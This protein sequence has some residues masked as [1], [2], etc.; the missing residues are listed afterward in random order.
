M[1]KNELPIAHLEKID[2]AVLKGLGTKNWE[3]INLLSGGLTGVPVYRIVVE[4]KSYTIKLEDVNDKE[5]DLQRSYKILETVSKQG[6]SPLV[7]FTDP[8]RGIVLMKYIES[9][10]RPEASPENIQKFSHLI[11]E[12][13][14]NNSFPKWK[15]VIVIL[16]LVY[17]RLTP[18]YQKSK[19]IMESMH[20]IN[21]MRNILFDQNDVRLC[22]CDLNPVNVLFDGEKYF[23][24]DW[25]AASAQSFYFDLAY[26]SNWF[27]FYNEDLCALFLTSYLG[28]EA[29]EEESAKYYLMRIFSYIYLGIGFISLPFREN[30]NIP[31]IPE[32]NIEKL[33]SYLKFMQSLGSGMVDLENTETQQQF[34]FIFLKTAKQMMDRRYQHAYEFLLNKKNSI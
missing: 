12:L 20:E 17:Q 29:T 33:P 10:P 3:L 26:C 8:D 32:E 2:F 34:G 31:I 18:D 11:R 1:K 30:Q 9:N 21:K 7:Y 4:N 13:H 16:E 19:I 28:R 25:Q 24:V 23:L 15:S 5:F 14:E 22:H 27:Y 6:I